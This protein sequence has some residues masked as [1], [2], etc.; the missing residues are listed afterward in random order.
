MSLGHA[1]WNYPTQ[2]RFGNGRVSELPEICHELEISKPLLVT[3]RGLAELPIVGRALEACAQGGLQATLFA[4]VDGNPVLQNVSDGLGALRE[5]GCDG[6]IALGGGSALDVGKAVALMAGQSRPLWDF[7]DVG[8]N[9][10]RVELDGIVPTIAVPTTAG[11]GSEVGRSSVITD[12]ARAR[13]VIIFHPTMM[14]EV[15]V[16]D[17]ELTQSLPAAL[18]AATGMDALSHSLEAYCARGNHPAADGIAVEGIRLVHDWLERACKTP[19]DLEARGQMLIASMLGATAFQKGL[20]A[21]HALSHPL[22]VHLGQHHG[23]INAV[24]MPYVLARNADAIAERLTRL[25]RFL[26]LDSS[27]PQAFVRR[28][29]DLRS[30]VGIPHT[31]R[32][33]RMTEA[34]VEAFAAEAVEDPAGFGNPVELDTAA[35]AD[36]YRHCLSGTLPER[37]SQQA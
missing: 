8:D 33:L 4:K 7:E 24:V 17:P 34:H 13:K 14:P 23:R 28:V 19:S 35:Y 22:G 2:V 36:L 32:E 12:P 37:R 11:T 15:A 31:L 30:S 18:T 1:D 6:V 10:K 20:G 9:W 3:D 21:M 29:L 25:S 5:A 16:L 27:S 26:E